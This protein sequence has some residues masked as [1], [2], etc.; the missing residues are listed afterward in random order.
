MRGYDVTTNRE[1]AS[2]VGITSGALYHYFESKLDLYL[3]V[4]HDV[5][6][7][8]LDVLTQAASRR[9]TFVEKFEEILDAT[10]EMNRRDPSVGRF[11]A[12]VRVDAQRHAEIASALR[13][14]RDLLVGFFTQLISEAVESGEVAKRNV[15]VVEAFV[16]TVLLGITA[17]LSDDPGFQETANEAV[18]RALHGR[19]L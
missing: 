5:Q 8:I 15:P 11:N 9:S 3:A 12:A 10:L 13:R 2:L 6:R 16:R 4:H 1:I 14:R 7:E 17:G 19:L 18:K